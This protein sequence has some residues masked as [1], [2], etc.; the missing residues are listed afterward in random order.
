LFTDFL[1][2]KLAHQLP[3]PS[4]RFILTLVNL[5]LCRI[6]ARTGQ[7]NRRTDGRARPVMRPI[8]TVTFYNAINDATLTRSYDK[9][10]TVVRLVDN[11]RTVYLLYWDS[12]RR[13]RSSIGIDI[14]NDL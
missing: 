6:N 4:W 10:R 2:Q 3:R 11:C 8:K 12:R 13:L 9:Q 1:N 7:T 14:Y 5:G